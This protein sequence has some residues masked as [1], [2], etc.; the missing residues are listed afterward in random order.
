MI[1][2]V[3]PPRVMGTCDSAAL[4]RNVDFGR[5]ARVNGTPALFFEDGTR[6][7]GA[8]P[9]DQVEKLLVAAAAATKKN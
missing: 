7:P 6:K 5:K 4:D 3:A 9:G 8:L 2:S 1:D